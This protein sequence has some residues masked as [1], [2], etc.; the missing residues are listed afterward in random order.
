MNPY[1]TLYMKHSHFSSAFLLIWFGIWWHFTSFLLLPRECMLKVIALNEGDL[2]VGNDIICLQI[3]IG[4]HLYRYIDIKGS[5]KL[6]TCLRVELCSWCFR[7]YYKANNQHTFNGNVFPTVGYPQCRW[8]SIMFLNR[9][10]ITIFMDIF[11]SLVLKLRTVEFFSVPNEEELQNKVYHFKQIYTTAK[12]YISL[13]HY[14]SGYVTKL[15]IKIPKK[16]C[17]WIQFWYSSKT[18]SKGFIM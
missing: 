1:C 18:F 3:F 7:A 15:T 13:N 5:N 4:L 17:Q 9:D 2:I 11:W 6:Y 8:S 14:L 10:S 12:L 16:S